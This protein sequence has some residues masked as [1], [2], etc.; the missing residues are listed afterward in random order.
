MTPETGAASAT[1]PRYNIG[2]SGF[3]FMLINPA[4]LKTFLHQFGYLLLKM[5]FFLFLRD[6]ANRRKFT[7]MYIDSS[8]SF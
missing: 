3:Y 7:I 6:Y 4:N 1:N 8:L 5:L 2:K